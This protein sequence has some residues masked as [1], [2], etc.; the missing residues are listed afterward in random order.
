[1]GINGGAVFF[2][3]VGKYH[4]DERVPV[5]GVAGAL[6]VALSFGLEGFGGELA[7]G[8]LQQNFH[9]GLGFFQLLLT[10]AGKAHAFLKQLHGLVERKLRAFELA[11]NFFE[12][13]EGA[14]KIWLFGRVRFF[15]SSL[16]HG[17]SSAKSYFWQCKQQ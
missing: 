5:G 1:M 13:P 17:I 14:L 7:I 2:K 16:I 4:R 8:F 10:F 11:H 15:R 9:A 6:R 3:K 12:T